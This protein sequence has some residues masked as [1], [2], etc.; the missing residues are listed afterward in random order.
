MGAT[1]NEALLAPSTIRLFGRKFTGPEIE[2][3][4]ARH[5][6]DQ[7]AGRPAEA[8]ADSKAAAEKAKTRSPMRTR[9]VSHG[10][11]GSAIWAIISS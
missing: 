5:V 9:M 11:T 4:G 10:S 2:D 3:F 1:L 6:L 7:P 8:A